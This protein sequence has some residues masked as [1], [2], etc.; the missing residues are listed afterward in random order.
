VGGHTS[1][2]GPFQVVTIGPPHLSFAS[3]GRTMASNSR[4]GLCI[5][6]VEP[7]R[8]IDP[9]GLVRHPGLTVT[10]ADCA[11]LAAAIAEHGR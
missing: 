3:R 6:F 11:G 9:A 8:G 5:E 4:R 10:V 2:T 7:V 1:T